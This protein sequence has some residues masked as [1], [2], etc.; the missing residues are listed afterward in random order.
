MIA[1][2]VRYRYP[3][4]LVELDVVTGLGQVDVLDRKHMRVGMS[5]Q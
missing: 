5:Q 4:L 3:E 1:R 2:A